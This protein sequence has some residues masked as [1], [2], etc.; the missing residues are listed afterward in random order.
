MSCRCLILLFF[1]V[2]AGVMAGL[3]ADTCVVDGIE[4]TYKVSNGKASVGVYGDEWDEGESAIRPSTTG[5]LKIP[6]VLGGCP[7]TSVGPYAFLNCKF[8][9]SVVIPNGIEEIGEWAFRGCRSLMSVSLPSSVESIDVSAFSSCSRLE[10]ISVSPDNTNYASIDDC[11]LSKDGKYLIRAPA[12]ANVAIPDGVEEIGYD[13][14]SGCSSLVSVSLPSSVDSI[15]ESVFSFCGRLES[16][17]VSPDNANYASIDNC[18]LS[19][20]GKYL[21]RAPAVA[22]VVIPDGVEEICE[23]AFSVCC[24][25]EEDEEIVVL[26]CNSLVSVS[27]PSSVESINEFVFLCCGRLEFISVSPDNADYASI[28]NCLLSK[29]GE[30]LIRAPAVANVVIPDGV[31]WIG[32]YAF[33]GCRSLVSVSIPESVTGIGCY[34]FEDCWKLTSIAIPDG[35]EW[36]D[37]DMFSGC[38]SLVDVTIPACVTRLT[39]TFPSSY[40]SIT[41]VVLDPSV[42]SIES[43]LFSGCRALTSLEISSN[44]EFIDVSA[45]SSCSRLE[46][47]SVSPDNA[48]FASIDNCLLSKDGKFLI[49]APAVANVVIPDGVEEVGESAFRGCSSLVSVSIPSSVT[50]IGRGAFAD[51]RQLTSIAIPDGVNRIENCTFSGC[52]SLM[53]VSIPPGVE[54][55]EADAFSGCSSLV[56]V[57]I[58]ACVTR[59]SDTFP[60]SYETITNVVLDSSVMDIDDGMFYG[61][62]SLTSVTIPEGVTRIGYDA[63][64]GCT[65]LVSVTIPSSVMSVDNGAFS[66]CGSLTSV[67]IPACVKRLSDTF[68]LSYET[69]TNVVLDSSVMDIDDGMFYGCTSLTSVTIPEG[70]TRIGYDA[71]AGCISLTSVDIP[72]SV[73]KLGWSAFYDC[74]SLKSVKIPACVTRLA[75]TFPSSYEMITNVVMDS[76]VTRIESSAFQDCR[77]LISVEIPSSVKS[78]GSEAFQNCESL[79]SVTI[80]EGVPR[81]ESYAFQG[82]RS[83]V[84][85]IIPSSVKNIAWNAFSDCS[86]LTSVTIPAC[87]TRLS[88]TFPSSYEK[89]ANVVMNSSVK[90]I[91]GN[92]FAGCSSLTSVKIPESVTSIEGSAFYGC[93][94]LS[95]VEIPS[96]VTNIGDSAFAMCESLVSVAIP[97]GVT[98]IERNAFYGCRALASVE[99]PSSVTNIGSGAFSGCTGL[100]SLSVSSGNPNFTLVNACLLITKDGKSLIRCLVTAGN[101]VIPDGVEDISD[102]AFSGC[103]SLM[104]VTIPQSVKYIGYNA[105][106]GCSSL[107]SV[108]IPE[109]VTEIGANVFSGCGSLASVSIPSSVE[110]IGRY[111]FSGC[112]HLADVVAPGNFASEIEVERWSMNGGYYIEVVPGVVGVKD[113]FEDSAQSITNLVITH[114]ETYLGEGCCSNMT[115]LASVTIPSSVTWIGDG[116]FRQCSALRSVTFEGD[117]PDIGENVFQGTSKRLSFLVPEG[118]IGWKGGALSSSDGLPETWNDRVISFSGGR[119]DGGTTPS[120]GGL[121]PV[122]MVVTNYVFSTVTNVIETHD[123]VNYHHYTEVTNRVETFLSVTNY[124]YYFAVTNDAGLVPGPNGFLDAEYA[125]TAGKDSP[126]IMPG[127]V[128]WDALDLPEGMTWDRETGTL[129]GT[130]VRSGVYDVILVSGSGADTRMM[131]TTVNVAGFDPVVGYVGTSFAWK[132]VPVSLF[133]SYKNL[134]KGLKWSSSAKALTGVPTAKGDFSRK[135]TYGDLVDFRILA[136]PA[137]AT[138]T[139][140]GVVTNAA[141][142]VYPVAVTATSAGKVTAKVTKGTKVYTLTA[143][144]WAGVAADAG[145]HRIFTAKAKATGGLTAVIAVDADADWRADSLAVAFAGGAVAGLSG[146][147]QRNAFAKVDDAKALAASLAGSY[148]LNLEAAPGGYALV[149]PPAGKKGKMSVVLKTTGV[150]TLTGMLDSKTTVS[151]TATVHVDA[152]GNPSLVFFYKGKRFDWTL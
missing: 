21:I 39:D 132:G 125:V 83:L 8:L 11:L 82:C 61:C 88:E 130:P 6:S 2:L 80:P 12:A 52:T 151:A 117:A 127:A 17:S 142:T 98:S 89:I 106:S 60:L 146:A 96:N 41:N 31:E 71:F 85:V 87:V 37:A 94:L 43:G 28:D 137:G 57:T 122:S 126:R 144:N 34:A 68:P 103:R 95:S 32:N 128:G 62:T 45:F 33:R 15:D 3:R 148:A 136:L 58:P 18:L 135:T 5:E 112:N 66:D 23:N 116:A 9:T 35:V 124:V 40:E 97:E 90:R 84:S 36:I 50:S 121:S 81:I 53:S 7:V 51:C 110:Y 47:I 99:I 38:S 72:S 109:G 77:S 20:D 4:W 1:C 74:C 111:A 120:G 10:F 67:T 65:S 27:I 118:S 29:D 140:N 79:V 115:A 25:D 59:L 64:S 107:K 101:V 22:N 119:Y 24:L 30:C 75:E 76:S 104:S 113:V 133:S 100:G 44:V 86:S 14:F 73:V 145:G 49:R 54:W 93:R 19:K 48:N 16:I 78:I 143:A 46:F 56:D 69:I 13:A 63:F 102:G 147:A 26:V 108:K 149:V 138:G 92:A 114:G 129:G 42:A 91:E 55:I 152:E 139:F 70:V 123:G 134:P 131:R 105:F 141:G 150:A